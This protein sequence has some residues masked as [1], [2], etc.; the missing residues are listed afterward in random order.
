MSSLSTIS[1]NGSDRGSFAI[2]GRYP[3][4]LNPRVIQELSDLDPPWGTCGYVVYKRTYSRMIEALGRTEDWHETVERCCNGIL[5]IGGRFTTEQI[6]RLAYYWYMLKGGMAGRPTWQLGTETVRRVGGDSMQNCLGGETE[7]ITREYGAISIREIVDMKVHVWVETERGAQWM[8][9]TFKSYGVQRLYDMTFKDGSKI[10]ATGDHQWLKHDNEKI[11]FGYQER[12][13][14]TDLTNQVRLP[15]ADIELPEADDSYLE[16]Y[17]HGFTFGD[18]HESGS[19]CKVEVFPSKVDVLDILTRYGTEGEVTVK[20]EIVPIVKGLPGHWKKLPDQTRKSRAY[21]L[22]FIFGL[23]SADG[24]V[25][26]IFRIH[27][28]SQEILYKVQRM[29]RSVG[30]Y[31]RDPYLDREISPFDGTIKECWCISISTHNLN[32]SYFIRQDQAAAFVRSQMKKTM[33]ISSIVDSGVDEEVFCCEVPVWHNFTLSNGVVTGQC[34]HVAVDHP[35]DPFTFAFNQLMLGGGVGFNVMP[36]Y[37]YAL[38]AVRHNVRVERVDTYDCDYIVSDNREGWVELLRRVLDAFFYGG[39]DFRYNTLC[40]RAKGRPIKGFGGVASGPEELVK[41]IAL[42][43][44]ILRN[45]VGR[46][47]RPTECMFI[48]NIIGQ[49]VVAGN[50]RR[51]AEI[52]IGSYEDIEF[53]QAKNWAI[54]NIPAWT[55][56]SNNTTQCSDIDLLPEIFWDGYEGRGEAYGLFNP[57]LCKSHGRLIDG[58]NYR[59]DYKIVG[60]N[61][62]GEIIL[63]SHEACNLSEIFLPNIRDVHEFG[64]VAALLFMANKAIS[65][66]PCWHPK[67][68]EVVDRN[69][70]IGIGVTGF[71]QAPHLNDEPDYFNAVYDHLE[72]VDRRISV[73]HKCSTSIKLT[74]IKPSGTM[75][76]LAGVTPGVHA[77]F[78][79]FYIRRITFAE[80]DPIVQ[81]AR[82]HGYNVSPKQNIDGSLDHSTMIVDFPTATPEGTQCAAGYSPIKQL[83]D[84]KF[85]QTYWSDN[86]VSMTCYFEKDEISEIKGWLRE[87]YPHSVKTASFTLHSEHGFKQAPYEEI[88]QDQFIELSS[89]TRPITNIVDHQLFEL[90]DSQECGSG[91]CPIK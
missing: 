1:R 77:A 76:L 28:K 5:E 34:W 53:L 84:Q 79:P 90:V 60:P 82:E 45:A 38:P 49:I 44:D 13:R 78:S 86:S 83:E 31:C 46:K 32:A 71:H 15:L 56:M 29:A 89:K 6:E 26:N 42:I 64:S 9:T 85:L 37:V 50:V 35:I 59:P 74:T 57:S 88:T 87:N 24:N 30:L 10:R 36:E 2:G 41:G 43:C 69:H 27:N 18:G 21:I 40:I 48:M 4:K 81:T 68:Q 52:A 61:P 73:E 11:Y 39:R 54:K 14:T 33:T 23:G 80:N 62:C 22:G 20:G 72:E 19:T 3:S 16:G 8:P 25:R 67:T 7:A 17:A 91:G 12:I 70:R 63:E 47:L 58:Y 55:Q 75:S 65:C 66:L 51:S